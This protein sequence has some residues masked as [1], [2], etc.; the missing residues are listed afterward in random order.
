MSITPQ[1][2]LPPVPVASGA[3]VIPAQRTAP[4][5]VPSGRR[6]AAR[7]RARAFAGLAT[8]GGAAL[9]AGSLLPWFTSTGATAL[10]EAQVHGTVLA[11]GAVLGTLL[12]GV[13]ALGIGLAALMGAAPRWLRPVPPL[14]A[15]LVALAVWS[16]LPPMLAE[17]SRTAFTREVFDGVQVS[18]GIG[19]G[20][21]ALV[22]GMAAVLLAGLPGALTRR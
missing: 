8:L 11:G 1:S 10:G 22:A 14:C 2:D 15:A 16:D 4:P 7:R 6:R 5:P 9:I 3:P 19:A 13:L 21:Y 12:P 20:L 18:T 17:L